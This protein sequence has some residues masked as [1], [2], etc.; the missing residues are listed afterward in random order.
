[1]RSLLEGSASYAFE[2]SRG[3]MGND[4]HM[5]GY[6]MIHMSKYENMVATALRALVRGIILTCIWLPIRQFQIDASFQLCLMIF[7]SKDYSN[8]PN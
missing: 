7:D 2:T 1:M 6:L 8:M 4:A 3:K 5:G